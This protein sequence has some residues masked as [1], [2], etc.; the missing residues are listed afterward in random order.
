MYNFDLACFRMYCILDLLIPIS[1]VYC[2]GDFYCDHVHV[3]FSST[4]A[5]EARPFGV[6]VL[7]IFAYPHRP[8]ICHECL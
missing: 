6:Q 3:N 7:Q 5:E 2:L 4:I 1:R 8:Q